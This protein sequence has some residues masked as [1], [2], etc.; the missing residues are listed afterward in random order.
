MWVRELPWIDPAEAA[1]RLA[2]LPSLA[3]LD[4]AMTHPTLGRY[5]YIAADPFGVFQ[6]REGRASWNGVPESAPPMEAL[7]RRMGLYRI[8]SRA[9]LPPFQGGAIGYI[10]YEFGWTLERRKPPV[11]SIGD[12]AHFAFHDLVVAFDHVARRCWVVASGFPEITSENRR[13][14]ADARIA[15]CLDVLRR[16][17]ATP[18]RRA[19]DV[20]WH[21]DMSPETYRAGVDHVRDYI[22]AGD[23]Y[24]A[25]IAQCFTAA[26]PEAVAPWAL[27]RALRDANPA[28]F[29]AYLS[30][31]PRQILC[32]S[33]ELF[34]R[35][36]GR[37]VETR[38]IKGT[39]RRVADPAADR[40]VAARLIG[41]RKDRAENVMIVDLLRNDLSRVCASASVHVPVLCGLETYAGLHHLVSSVTGELAPGRD[42]LDLVE[43]SFPGGS[44]TGAPKIRAM[45]IIGEIEGR[46][47]GVYCGALGFLGFDGAVGF[48]IAIRTIVVESGRMELRVGGGITILSDPDS[49]YEETLTKAQRIFEAFAPIP[50][51]AGLRA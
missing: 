46:P 2:E 42:A 44:I 50:A 38:P 3:F 43:A 37:H 22:R 33:P 16:P 17:R 35:S 5:S 15:R 34:L 8:A 25:N 31:G 27:Y 4:S 23:I 11:A 26:V 13:Q 12:D 48:N 30:C 40:E 51:M 29:G 36:D 10:G 39:A 47:R 21:P 6:V 7:R 14:R 41:S 24:Q 1:S 9:D 32:T 20:R 45:E 28:P 19:P 49:E 18:E